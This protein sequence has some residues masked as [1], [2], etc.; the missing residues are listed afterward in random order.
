M[1]FSVTINE[2]K[3]P[4]DGMTSAFEKIFAIRLRVTGE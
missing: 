1:F 3:N 4:E 2:N